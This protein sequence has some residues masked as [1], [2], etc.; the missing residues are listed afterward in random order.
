MAQDFRGGGT[1]TGSRG[2]GG[3]SPLAFDAIYLTPGDFNA[4]AA[5]TPPTRGNNN[6]VATWSFADGATGELVTSFLLPPWNTIGISFFWINPNA[7]AGNVRWRVAVKTLNTNDLASEA[8]AADT[9]ANVAAGAQ[10]ALVPRINHVTGLNVA[11]AGFGSTYSVLISRI[12][13]DAGDTLVGAA[14]LQAVS[15]ARQS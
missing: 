1:G 10:N 15:F 14:E 9:S 13:A 11:G 3:A 7:G 5:G 8:F 4:T 6:N 12:G 2:G